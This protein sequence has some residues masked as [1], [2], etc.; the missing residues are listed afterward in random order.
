[1]FT[2]FP[3][4]GYFDGDDRI[5]QVP[6]GP[7]CERALLSDPGGTS[8][9]GHY[10]ASVLSS[11]V[12][13]MS[14]PAM[15]IISRLNHT[16]RPLAVYASQDGLLHHHARLASGWLACLSGQGCIPTGSRRKVSGKSDHPIPLSQAFL[17][18]P[19]FN[20]DGLGSRSRSE[21]TTSSSLTEMI[22]EDLVAE[23]V[24]VES[25]SEI[26]RWLGADDITT[27][28]VMESILRVEARAEDMKKLLARLKLITSDRRK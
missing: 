5:S 18:H 25:Y 9:L 13:T 14:T 10:R 26:I 6:G 27:R 21:Y 24:A 15:N 19:N 17:A 7:H 2:G 3:V 8:A 23:R 20:P 11:T 4:T 16:A 12:R 1:L 22:R 28:T